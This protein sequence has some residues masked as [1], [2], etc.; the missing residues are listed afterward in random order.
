MK[1]V[2]IDWLEV[3]VD[4]DEGFTI[5][6]FEEEGCHVEVREYGTRIYNIMATIHDPFLHGGF[7]IR[8]SP[9]SSA[10][11]SVSAAHLKV[12][13]KDCY[14]QDPA[15]FIWRVICKYRMTYRSI[16]RVDLAT[17]FTI[18]DSGIDPTSFI[19]RV[20]AGT[21][22]RALKSVRKDVVQDSWDNCTPNYIAYQGRDVTVRLYD[23]T[24]ELIQVATPQKRAYIGALWVRDGL[25]PSVAAMYS[26]DVQHVFR[27]EFQIQSSSKEWVLDG[28]G[29][30]MQAGI[31]TL[32]SYPETYALFAGLMRTYFDFYVYKKESD[33]TSCAQVRLMDCTKGMP[34]L[35][36]VTSREV[37]ECSTRLEFLEIAEKLRTWSER[38]SLK[39]FRSSLETLSDEV[40]KA[41]FTHPMFTKDEIIQLQ[42]KMKDPDLFRHG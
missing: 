37:H 7:E 20:L 4:L 21:Y 17:D 28:E 18:F 9:K 13:N 30:Y 32:C 15:D 26:K 34:V 25:I 16:S 19:R 6:R 3:F 27:L 29:Q 39:E 40:R 36:P 5:E 8:C 11:L 1:Y 33:P 23:K 14:M 24:L 42:L 38:Y 10:I 12:L 22:R 35:K 41:A 2:V 31:D